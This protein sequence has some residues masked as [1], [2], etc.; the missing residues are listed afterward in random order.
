ME[1]AA[2]DQ[3]D[4]L[5]RIR[6]DKLRR[7]KNGQFKK[8]DYLELLGR[9]DDDDALPDGD[10]GYVFRVLIDG[11]LYAL[12]IFRFFD[13]EEALAMLDP[14]GRS[15]VSAEDVEGQKDPFYAEC[16]AY[17]RIASKKRKR[18]IA[19]ACHGFV[20]IPAKQEAV[21][22]WRF[23]IADWSRP[24]E[25]LSL[26]PAQQQPLRGLVKDLVEADP[27]VTEALVK[28]MRRELK[29]LN[30]LRIYVMDVRW[31]NYKGGHL[32]D[33]S[34]AWTEP[35]FEFRR[36]VNSKEDIELNRQVDLQ[37][38]DKMV[39]ELGMEG[40]ARAKPD[41]AVSSRLRHRRGREG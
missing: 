39:G 41:S 27:E 17:A 10:H 18:P 19:V 15:C 23:G 40:L 32:V 28:A 13:V 9:S 3:F 16:R 22:A 2:I 14:A 25:Q 34:S 11:D 20:S 24:E 8:I 36:D 26:P 5:P 37:A 6:G 21:L 12:K 4:E 30:S 29:A 35:H 33:F 1:I 7:F 31:D 38:F